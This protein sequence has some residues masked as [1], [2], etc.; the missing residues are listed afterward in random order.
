MSELGELGLIQFRDVSLFFTSSPSTFLFIVGT[1]YVIGF[2]VY[3][4]FLFY[5]FVLVH[6]YCFVLFIVGTF[7][8]IGFFVYLIFLFYCFVLVHFYC[9]VLFIVGTFYVIVLSCHRGVPLSLIYFVH[10]IFLFQCFCADIF[11]IVISSPFNLNRVAQP[12]CQQLPTHL[13]Q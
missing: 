11:R 12:K 5:C 6:F 4:I 7:Y 9:F 10:L 1:F 3:L 8:V 13:R 2:F